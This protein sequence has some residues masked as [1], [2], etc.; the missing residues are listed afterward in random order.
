VD[1]DARKEARRLT[2]YPREKPQAYVLQK[3][4]ETVSDERVKAAVRQYDLKAAARRGIVYH[5]GL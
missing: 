3:V 2:D 1:F 4:R 5:S